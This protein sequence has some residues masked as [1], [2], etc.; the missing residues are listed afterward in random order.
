MFKEWFTIASRMG[1]HGQVE[2]LREV[3]WDII[4]YCIPYT[5]IIFY[6]VAAE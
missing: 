3:S 1:F 2:I 6:I 4:W 5:A